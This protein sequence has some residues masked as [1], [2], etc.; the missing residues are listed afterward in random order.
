MKFLLII[1]FI[2]CSLTSTAQTLN[3][4]LDIGVKNSPLLKEYNLQLQSGL[5]DSLK[6]LA[7]YKPQAGISSEIMY[8]PAIWKFAYD[9]AITDGGHYS[10]LASV[11]QPLFNKKFVKAK[12]QSVALQKL[13]TLNNKKISE[14][15]LKEAITAQYLSA[16]IVFSRIQFEKSILKLLNEERSTLKMLVDKGIYQKTDYLNLSVSITAREIEGKQL[17]MEYKNDVA[18]LNLI[19]GIQ[20]T[21]TISLT[22]PD[23]IPRTSFD[24]QNS[25]LMVQF[26]IDSLKNLNEKLLID[27]QYLPRINA[28]ADAGILASNP[29]YIPYNLGTSFGLNLSMPLYDGKQK[30][31]ERNRID[32]QEDSRTNYKSAFETRYLQQK[33]QLIEQLDLSDD[34]LAEIRAQITDLEKLIT[35]YKAEINQGLVRWLDFI[36]VI[37]NYAETTN[38]LTQTEINHLQIINQLNYLK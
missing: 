35:L 24:L 23:I 4:Y 33:N 21:A 8:P 13:T 10:A 5:I 27:Q 16:Y 26:R 11:T 18:I 38:N 30:Q 31:L 36:M 34:L 9:S 28:F 20:D 6:V 14:A 12:L 15:D 3:D 2:A 29:R 7:G 32:L 1:S 37:N 17:F 22:K 25:P 19:C